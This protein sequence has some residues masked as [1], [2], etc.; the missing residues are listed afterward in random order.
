M[1]NYQCLISV[2]NQTIYLPI[3]ILN[4]IS[5]IL[6]P[7]LRCPKERGNAI[8]AVVLSRT[9]SAQNKMSCCFLFLSP[10]LIASHVHSVF[11]MDESLIFHPQNN[12]WQC[13]FECAHGV[14]WMNFFWL[15]SNEAIAA[16]LNQAGPKFKNQNSSSKDMKGLFERL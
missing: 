2:P 10:V 12:L 4:T 8:D 6:H 15:F 7:T 16:Y 14:R 5:W 1:H 11:Q 3:Q 9:W 13:N